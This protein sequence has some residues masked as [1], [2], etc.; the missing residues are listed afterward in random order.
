M[1]IGGV[2]MAWCEAIQTIDF[3]TQLSAVMLGL[4]CL[5]ERSIDCELEVHKAPRRS[6]Q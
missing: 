4:L 5:S 1:N 6:I 3:W 2:G